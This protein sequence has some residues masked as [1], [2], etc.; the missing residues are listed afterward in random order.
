MQ[1]RNKAFLL[2]AAVLMAAPG[3]REGVAGEAARL[4]DVP[5]ARKPMAPA[6]AEILRLRRTKDSPLPQGA[7]SSQPSFRPITQMPY[8]PPRPGAARVLTLRERQMLDQDKNW[9]FQ[10]PSETGLT[11]RNLHRALGVRSV[12]TEV[13]E[14]EDSDQ[15]MTAMERYVTSQQDR[16]RDLTAG[17]E[18]GSGEVTPQASWMQ[19]TGSSPSRFQL[20]P[21]A[22]ALREDPLYLE[23]TGLADRTDPEIERALEAARESERELRMTLQQ[24]AR[25][26]M[27]GIETRSLGRSLQRGRSGN[28]Q[29]S[30]LEGLLGSRAAREGERPVSS[31]VGSMLDPVNAYP[32]LTRQELDPVVARP[33]GAGES[34][35]SMP[36]F[37][38]PQ[39]ASSSLAG[40]SSRGISDLLRPSAANNSLMPAMSNPQDSLQPSYSPTKNMQLRLQLPGRTF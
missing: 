32:D 34:S 37:S 30:A 29:Q 27:F 39:N 10:D 21:E 18:E 40:R 20:Q 1:A 26:Q 8:N 35:A 12:E 3:M 13:E 15:L 24:A 4:S 16:D 2:S 38:S 5:V 11:D 9:I 17:G 19:D 33:N 36:L 14:G 22:Q 25:G 28:R 31:R 6:Q 7:A 23:M